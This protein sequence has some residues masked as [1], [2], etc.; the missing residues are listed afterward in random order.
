MNWKAETEN[1]LNV[2]SRDAQNNFSSKLSQTKNRWVFWV[3]DKTIRSF[4]IIERENR[5]FSAERKRLPLK[6]KNCM[7]FLFYQKKGSKSM[8]Q[9]TTENLVMKIQNGD[10]SLFPV[11]WERLER[12]FF[13]IVKNDHGKEKEAC[14]D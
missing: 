8:Q 13:L 3:F 14:M 6:D 2:L 4:G 9:E 11:L 7:S 5:S 10:T 12:L 1:V